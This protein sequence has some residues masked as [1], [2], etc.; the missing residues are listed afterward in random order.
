[1]KKPHD[2]VGVL[3]VNLG[4]PDSPKTGDVRKYLRE[5]LMDWR[6][7]DYP[8]IPRWML[9]NLIIA[10]FRAPKSAKEYQKLWQDRGSPLKF[11]GEDVTQLLQDSLGERYVVKLA[12]RYQKPGIKSVLEELQQEM[13]SSIICIPLFPQYASATNGSVID[14]VMEITRN[15]QVIPELKFISQFPDHTLFIE[16][17]ADRARKLMDKQEYDHYVFSYHGV[18]VSQ[19][20]KASYGDYCQ[21]GSCCNKYGKRNQYCYRAQCFQTSRVL[22]KKLGIPE[23]KY[24]V[25]FQSRLGPV[26][27]IKPYT[28]EVLEE[29]AKEGK[30]KV[31]ALSPAFVADC[32]ETTLEVGEEYKHDFL[33]AGGEVWDLVESLNDH[34]IWIECLKDL[35]LQNDANAD[36]SEEKIPNKKTSDELSS[37]ISRQRL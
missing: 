14:K 23:E 31:L 6:V 4:T 15:W 32:L 19:I 7:V 3:L 21:V 27:W 10:P 1:M 36:I 34:P 16:A 30:K 29:L 22:A 35:V 13:V 8:L 17:H 2:K 5:F 24:T 18:P 33:D 9:V 11:Y 37:S 25:S 12:M 26:P 28:D 20:K